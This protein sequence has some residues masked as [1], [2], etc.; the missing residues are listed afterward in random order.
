MI[1]ETFHLWLV[2][3][4]ANYEYVQQ[5]VSNLKFDIA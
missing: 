2:Y 3:M 5:T 4:S 1:A